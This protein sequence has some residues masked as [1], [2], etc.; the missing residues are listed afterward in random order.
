[1]LSRDAD[2][3]A[4][5][6]AWI[7]RAASEA[8]KVGRAPPYGAGRTGVE[9]A[10]GHCADIVEELQSGGRLRLAHVRVVLGKT[11][12]WPRPD[13]PSLI[14]VRR[15]GAIGLCGTPRRS[16]SRGAL[17]GSR[18][19]RT[20]SGPSRRTVLRV[21]LPGA[22]TFWSAAAPAADVPA[23]P[24]RRGR[25]WVAGEGCDRADGTPAACLVA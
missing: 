4:R 5:G 19:E 14:N 23:S 15:C 9:Q 10:P 8:L 21:W 3:G 16:L 13:V 22:P 17:P 11:R 1:M 20:K 6:L 2:V 7:G 24:H 18:D 25:A 12:E